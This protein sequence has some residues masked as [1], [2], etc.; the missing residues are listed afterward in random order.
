MSMTPTPAMESSIKIL[1]KAV[2]DKKISNPETLKAASDVLVA[3]EYLSNALYV[4]GKSFDQFANTV[5][6]TGIYG[7]PPPEEQ[8]SSDE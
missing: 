8:P 6:S 2:E 7:A 1:S 3:I 4:I 5:I